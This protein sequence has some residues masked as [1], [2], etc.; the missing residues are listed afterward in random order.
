MLGP[1]AADKVPDSAFGLTASFC[2]G[3]VAG[4]VGGA[5]AF[6]VFREPTWS[7]FWYFLRMPSLWYF[8]NCLEAS[9]PPTRW[10]IFFPPGCSSCIIGQRKELDLHPIAC[11]DL[12]LGQ[13]VDILVDDDPQ[14]V[15]LV[16]RLDVGFGE[17]TRHACRSVRRC[18]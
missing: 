15:G 6:L 18:M 13:V 4:G 7:D 8:Q 10:R 1:G 12:E 16:M 9:L 5:A 17:R 11:T 14:R 3:G 2:G